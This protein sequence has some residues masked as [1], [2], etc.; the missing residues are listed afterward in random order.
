MRDRRPA[1]LLSLVLGALLTAAPS[2]AAGQAEPEPPWTPTPAERQLA[3]RMRDLLDAARSE[4][5]LA[6][7]T[8]DPN[9]DLLAYQ[10]SHEMASRGR[11]SHFSY[12]FGVSTRSRVKLAFP[13]V[14]QFGENVARNAS[15]EALHAA[16]MQSPGH[17]LNRMDPSFT[18]AGMGVARGSDHQLYVTE[19]FVRVGDP[20]Q[21]QLHTLYTTADPGELPRDEPTHGEIASETVTVRPPGTDDPAYWTGLGIDA[22]RQ[23]RYA[24]A[25]EHFRHALRLSPDYRFATFNLGRALLHA[26]HP[27]EAL[28]VLDRYLE[29]SPG[30]TEAWRAIGSAALLTQDYSRAESALRRVLAA[31]TRDAAAWY[32]L[33]LSVEYQ[34]RPEEAERAYMQALHLDPDLTPARDALSRVR[35]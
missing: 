6:A 24:D 27:D 18:H 17:R 1:V 7:L 26:G 35:G 30:D 3:E 25:V 34:D 9:L 19:V 31:D 16:L 5:G 4:A 14:Y 22:F 33:G 13:R 2:V 21:L 28:V 12:R 23:E 15:P 11:V 29:T 20:S 32:N 8:D 10:H